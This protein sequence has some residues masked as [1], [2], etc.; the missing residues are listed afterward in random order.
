HYLRRNPHVT[1]PRNV[2]TVPD[3]PNSN[4][5]FPVK[6][7]LQL[8]KLSGP[9]GKVTAACGLGVYRDDLLGPAYTNNAFICEPVNLVLNRQVLQP[10][11]S[12]FASHRA[13]GEEQAEFLGATDN[14]FR[15]VQMRTGPDGA[16]WVVDMYRLVIE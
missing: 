15:P 11:G 10:R 5:V 12:T 1:P 6:R 9:P 16:L 8:F 2:V 14:W 7:D 3:Y 13:P 4:R